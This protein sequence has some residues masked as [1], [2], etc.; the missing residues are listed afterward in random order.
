MT[1][2]LDFAV[3]QIWA[4][5]TRPAEPNA[6]LTIVKIDQIADIT[7]V[8]ISLDGLHIS[9]P[10]VPQGYG[11]SVGHMPIASESLK[12]SVTQ[13]VGQTDV[14]PDYAEGYQT[15]KAAFDAGEGGFFTIGLAECIGYMETAINQSSR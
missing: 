1:E 5:Q 11:E 15:W 4:Y 6:R 13:L 10:H 12:A 7:I 8:H 14:L 3:G 9:N 2:T